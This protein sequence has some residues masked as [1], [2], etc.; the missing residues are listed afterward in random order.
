MKHILKAGIAKH[1]GFDSVGVVPLLEVK[2]IST[3]DIEFCHSHS[4]AIVSDAVSGV[5][6]IF[7]A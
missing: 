5:L 4:L 3:G 1:T 2:V 7:G 6:V